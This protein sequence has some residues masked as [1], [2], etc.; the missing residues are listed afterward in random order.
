M[1]Q[2]FYKNKEQTSTWF[3]IR[4]AKCVVFPPAINIK[5]INSNINKLQ[6]RNPQNV[7]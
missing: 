4:H 3:F 7:G 6:K 2:S 1:K 5:E